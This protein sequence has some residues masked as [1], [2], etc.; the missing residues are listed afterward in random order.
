MNRSLIS[1]LTHE[2]MP[3]R[4]Q[5]DLDSMKQK[6]VKTAA[7]PK[8]RLLVILGFAFLAG[9]AGLLILLAWSFLFF[10]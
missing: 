4:L 1:F 5:A 6:A 2:Q 9:I 3:E 8:D 7:R 10:A